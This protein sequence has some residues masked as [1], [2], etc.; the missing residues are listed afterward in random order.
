MALTCLIM[1]SFLTIGQRLSWM[2]DVLFTSYE[3]QNPI[4]CVEISNYHPTYLGKSNEE[5]LSQNF[6]ESTIRDTIANEHGFSSWSKVEE[7]GKSHIN[8]DFEYAVNHLLAG[9]LIALKDKIDRQPALLSARSQYGHR[10]SVLN[11]V[12]SNGVEFWRQQV[13]INLVAVTE[14]LLSTGIDSN[15][16]FF[17]YGGE[18]DTKAM[19][20]SSAHPYAAGIADNLLALFE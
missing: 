18:Y 10:A 8:W 16:T 9:D 20:S 2:S 19:I 15:Q 12:G 17:I 5:L 4:S 6:D 13:P 11:Y 7:V 14:Y 1:V 3:A